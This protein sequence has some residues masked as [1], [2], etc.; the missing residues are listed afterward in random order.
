MSLC[1]GLRGNSETMFN[2][3]AASAAAIKPPFEAYTVLEVTVVGVFFMNLPL[4]GRYA[5][6]WCN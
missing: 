1:R 3:D 5:C 4:G 6:F 2:F